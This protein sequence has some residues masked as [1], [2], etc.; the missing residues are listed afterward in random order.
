MPKALVSAFSWLVFPVVVGGLLWAASSAMDRGYAPLVCVVVFQGVGVALI[1]GLEW[2]FPYYRQWHRYK[3]DVPADLGHSLVSGILVPE[4][5]RPF[6]FISMVAVAAWLSRTIG[7][8]LWPV[9]W[10]WAFQLALA[11]VVGEF[12]QYWAHRLEHEHEFLWRLHATHHSAPRLYF[13]N[14]GRFHPLDFLLLFVCWYAPLVALGCSEEILAL[15]ALFTTL[16]G[17]FQHSNLQIRLGPLNWIFSMAELHRWHHSRR[18]E[19]ANAN[20]GAN[21]IVWDV[22]FGTR[23]LPAGRRPPAAIGIGDLPGFPNGYFAQLLSP[24]RWRRV[25][26]ESAPPASGG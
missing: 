18:L 19:E 17:V 10:P 8:E 26:R 20:Y 9:A 14:A 11:L 7:F 13:L 4:L 25:V 12:G 21:L 6:I 24:F 16:H 22:V 5:A 23:R 3:G 2:V 15:F 1:A